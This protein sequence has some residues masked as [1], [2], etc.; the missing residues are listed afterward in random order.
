MPSGLA[1]ILVCHDINAFSP[2]GR[3]TTPCQHREDWRDAIRRDVQPG[4]PALGLHLIHSIAGPMSFLQSY[5]SWSSVT[6]VPLIGVG[7]LK[8]G[9]TFR[10]AREL[11]AAHVRP[12]GLPTFD[13]WAR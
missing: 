10:R 7:S 3:A 5:N 6:G 8:G 11:A 1:A 12:A 2:R 13:L 4:P 9:I